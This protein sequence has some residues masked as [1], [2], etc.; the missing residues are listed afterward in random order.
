MFGRRQNAEIAGADPGATPQPQ[1]G[2]PVAGS[3]AE[4][5]RSGPASPP[6]QRA[7]PQPVNPVANEKRAA[8]AK[9]VFERIQVALLERIDA[10]AAAKLPREELQRQ[11]AELIGEIVAEE[12][13]SLT[14]RSGS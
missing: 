12:K 10:S 11:I 8:A 14:S 13:L 2:S 3:P 7:Q 9:A 1:P 5:A 6:A 4:A